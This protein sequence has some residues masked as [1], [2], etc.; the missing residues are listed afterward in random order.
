MQ[1]M[2]IVAVSLQPQLVKLH[3]VID[4]FGASR[5][6]SRT[7]ERLGFNAVAYDV[8]LNSKHDV[9]SRE[10]FMTLVQMGLEYLGYVWIFLDSCGF[11]WIH[12]D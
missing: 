2:E 5:K 8:K 12:M 3:Q 4:L 1:E 11:V 10:G 6:V 9:V 7:W